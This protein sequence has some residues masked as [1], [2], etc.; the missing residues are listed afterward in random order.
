MK[1]DDALRRLLC[2]YTAPAPDEA[3]LH[4]TV[5]RARVE[6]VLPATD[7]GRVFSVATLVVA[8]IVMALGMCY[9][10]IVGTVLRYMLPESFGGLVRQS[11]FVF[12]G[13]GWCMMACIVAIVAVTCLWGNRFTPVVQPVRPM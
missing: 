11:L 12:G 9:M 5:T 1:D 13:A 3:L 2:T 7:P 10:L 4:R 6:I 8:S